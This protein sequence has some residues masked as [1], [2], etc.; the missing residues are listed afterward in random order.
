MPLT[1]SLPQTNF[2]FDKWVEGKKLLGKNLAELVRGYIKEEALKEKITPGLAVILVGDD[3]ASQV[4]VGAKEKAAQGV[5]F[6]SRIVRLPKNAKQE[7]IVSHIHTF[8]HDSAIHG[9][10]VQ[11]PLPPHVNEQQVLQSILPE[12]DADGFH[13]IN[14]GK[15][16]AGEST[17]LACTPAG[18]IL[19][20]KS[21][22][23]SLAGK[24][25]VVVGR[26]NIV[27]KPMAQLLLS[28]LNMTTTICHSRTQNLQQFVS[29]ADVLVSAT[30]VRQII[31]TTRV[32]EGSIVI[33]VGMHR[34][35]GKLTGDLDLAPVEGRAAF[36]TPVPGGV[37]PMTIA[38]LLFNT[39]QNAVRINKQNLIA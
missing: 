23:V 13:F 15:L 30:G 9:I 27:G 38:M 6:L 22:P 1:D 34:V 2:S 36:Y 20:L 37:G 25:A 26:S 19:M 28:L 39:F 29:A 16:L 33:D 4:Y 35:D 21:L 5:G 32:K 3:A 10:L 11:L 8:N 17:T 7:E 31:D 24:H 18:I 14:Q 12:K